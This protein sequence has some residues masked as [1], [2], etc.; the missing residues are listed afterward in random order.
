MIWVL[1]LTVRQLLFQVQVT[2]LYACEKAQRLG[3]Q[4]YFFL[5]QTVKIVDEEGIDSV[6]KEIKEV[7]RGR[8]KDYLNYRPNAKVC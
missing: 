1:T 2:L 7:K 4:S 3:T 6:I 5:T 8:I